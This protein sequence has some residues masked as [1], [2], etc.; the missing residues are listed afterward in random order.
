MPNKK[1]KIHVGN[2]TLQ[3]I[4]ANVYVFQMIFFLYI[5]H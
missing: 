4:G 2:L 3:N 5:F 1:K